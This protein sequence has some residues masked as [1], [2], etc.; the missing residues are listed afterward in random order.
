MEIKRVFAAFLLSKL[1]QIN[2]MPTKILFELPC[3]RIFMLLMAC[4]LGLGLGL[5]F[6]P[7]QKLLEKE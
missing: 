2:N 3:A 4:V 1:N 5:K 6:N 7:T